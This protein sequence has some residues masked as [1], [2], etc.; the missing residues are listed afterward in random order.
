MK[1]CVVN[2][3]NHRLPEYSTPMSAGI[4]L[5]ANISEP[6]TLGP[7]QRILIPTDLYMAIPEGYELQIRSRS[8]LALKNGIFC[9]NSP[10]TVDADY[11]GNVGVIL[12]NFSD[13]PFIINPGD[14]VAQAVLNK[15][16]KIEWDEVTTL[17]ETERGT[18]GFGHSG[19]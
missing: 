19:I 14:R 1:V 6:I 7:L 9:L 3:S 8:G 12:A 13:T 11:R 2:K 5:K 17:N 18:G 4:D 15:F 10:G 16:E